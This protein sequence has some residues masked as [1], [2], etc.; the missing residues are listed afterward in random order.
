M[1]GRS[2]DQ[3]QKADKQ[4]GGHGRRQLGG[5]GQPALV[6]VEPGLLAVDHVEELTVQSLAVWANNFDKLVYCTSMN[7]HPENNMF[8]FFININDFSFSVSQG[9]CRGFKDP[10]VANFF[11]REAR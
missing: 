6:V 1:K 8:T 9:S 4:D 11:Q 7:I 2:N 5:A 10:R 3:Q